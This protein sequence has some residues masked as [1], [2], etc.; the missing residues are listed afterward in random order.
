MSARGLLR[1]TLFPPSLVSCL[2]YRSPAVN[3][4]KQQETTALL[5]S[6]YQ[7]SLTFGYLWYSSSTAYAANDNSKKENTTRGHSRLSACN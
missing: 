5:R 2:E 6:F 7:A 1:K 3:L 4:K